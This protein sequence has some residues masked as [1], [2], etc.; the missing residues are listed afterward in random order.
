MELKITKATIFPFEKGGIGLVKG[1]ADIELNGALN[2]YSLRIVDRDGK[3]EVAYPNDPFCRGD[4]I[5]YNVMPTTSPEGQALRD[6][7]SDA[8]L[9]KYRKYM[10]GKSNG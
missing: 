1:M 2:I 3:L 9:T 10:E 4:D 8:V 5:K 6:A 7:I